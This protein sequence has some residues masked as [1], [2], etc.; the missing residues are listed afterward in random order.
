MNKED[1]K[2]K[3]FNTEWEIKFVDPLDDALD[4][5]IG[6]C[7]Y[8][9]DRIYIANNL[10]VCSLVASNTLL[11]NLSV[12]IKSFFLKIPLAAFKASISFFVKPNSVC[13]IASLS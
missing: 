12:S 2:V 3:I 4:G 11:I 13:N 5:N 9:K 7:L 1:L 10:S 8:R 6:Y